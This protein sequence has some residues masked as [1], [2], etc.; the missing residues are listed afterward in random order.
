MSD[1]R[2][3]CQEEVQDN[4]FKMAMSL[5]LKSVQG[6]RIRCAQTSVHMIRT[7]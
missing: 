2:A 7:S 5:I 6:K 3:R 1:A 4:I